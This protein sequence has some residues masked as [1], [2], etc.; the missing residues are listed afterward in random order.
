MMPAG[1]RVCDGP[2]MV[3]VKLLS[4]MLRLFALGWLTLGC[5]TA[6]ICQTSVDVRALYAELWAEH[7]AAVPLVPAWCKTEH[8][9]STAES[10]AAFA[11]ADAKEGVETI[12]YVGVFVILCMAVAIQLVSRGKRLLEAEALRAEIE[13][14]AEERQRAR[15]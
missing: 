4:Y 6:F 8:N 13:A 3:V 7:Y 14:E 1:W 9:S 11:F 12:A 2:W 15:P 5:V 10:C